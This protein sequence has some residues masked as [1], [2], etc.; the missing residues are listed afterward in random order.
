MVN[1]EL[2]GRKTEIKMAGILRDIGVNVFSEYAALVGLVIA[3]YFITEIYLRKKARFFGGPNGEVHLYAS[4]LL[5]PSGASFGD[6]KFR[7]YMGAAVPGYEI[8]VINEFSKFFEAKILGFGLPELL[9][10]LV[11]PS[12]KYV[13]TVSPPQNFDLNQDSETIIAIGSRGY[14]TVSKAIEFIAPA[15]MDSTIQNIEYNGNL[16]NGH[17][18][19][20][21]IINDKSRKFIYAAGLSAEGTNKASKYLM[22]N[23]K[24]ILNLEISNRMVCIRQIQN[25]GNDK[26]IVF[27]KD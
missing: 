2:Y 4:N 26:T 14:N 19:F 9:S 15:K 12:P 1:L 3:G 17:H 20:V 8:E 18:Y 27:E 10:K 23:W 11:F 22:E 24:W 25:V 16:Y 21:Q 5:I 7:S 6:G 13:Y